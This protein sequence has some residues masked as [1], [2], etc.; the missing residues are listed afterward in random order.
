MDQINVGNISKIERTRLIELLNSHCDCFAS[1]PHELGCTNLG[2]MH[3]KTTIE[4][5]IIRES[6]S[7]YASPI[8]LVRKKW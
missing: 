8:L 2:E 7:E 1:S 6:T 5:H 4:S 3:I